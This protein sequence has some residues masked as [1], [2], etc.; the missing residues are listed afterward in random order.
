MKNLYNQ[1]CR[2][3][4]SAP[5]TWLGNKSCEARVL[6]YCKLYQLGFVTLV[7]LVKLPKMLKPEMML[8]ET[9]KCTT[10]DTRSRMVL[11]AVQ[12]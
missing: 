3:G 12:R 8:E 7:V 2:S 4:W 5:D 11:R 10:S 6:R 9:I 1:I